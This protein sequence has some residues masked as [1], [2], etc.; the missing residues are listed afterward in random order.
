MAFVR[1]TELLAPEAT[2][3]ELVDKLEPGAIEFL[4]P[5]KDLTFATPP[6]P[7]NDHEFKLSVLQAIAADY[8][9]P[10]ETLTGDL[11][12]VNFSSARMGWN[13]FSRNVNDWRWNLLAPQCLN[14]LIGW[15]SEAAAL[16]GLDPQ[17][18][19]PLWSAPARVMVDESREIPA[20]RDKVRAGL[21]S[22]PEAIRQQGYDP[23]T[24]I[25]E[26]AAFNALLDGLGLKLDT[27]PRADAAR[28]TDL[29]TE[30]TA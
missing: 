8:G 22:L 6:Q 2:T 26:T 10:Y 24:L 11:S 23:E 9:L 21:M 25:R 13:E 20:I 1:D 3:T 30:A 17:G 4:P 16:V 28:A 5:G 29:V 7:E 19:T 14:P 15:F 27:D 12:Q 18:A